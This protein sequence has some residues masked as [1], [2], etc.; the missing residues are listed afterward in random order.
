MFDLHA[1]ISQFWQFY[2]IWPGF[3]LGMTILVIGGLLWTFGI[4][5]QLRIAT[6]LPAENRRKSLWLA[7]T[8]HGHAIISILLLVS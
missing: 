6:K 1:G 8:L 2:W 7:H 4:F 5:A 3:Y